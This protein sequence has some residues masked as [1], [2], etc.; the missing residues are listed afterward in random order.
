MG[1]KAEAHVRD[2][3]LS[4]PELT[5]PTF[6]PTIKPE[7]VDTF[8]QRDRRLLLGVSVMEQ[9][10]GFLCMVA[11]EGNKHLRMLERRTIRLERW[12]ISISGPLG[13]VLW[14]ASAAL[15]FVIRE[16]FFRG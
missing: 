16:L 1:P 10:L 12:R 8:S 6:S 5:M 7:D 11:V 13:V 2:E 14:I 15:P 9:Q 3:D 4:I